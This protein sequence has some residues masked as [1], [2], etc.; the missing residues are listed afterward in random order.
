MRAGSGVDLDPHDSQCLGGQEGRGPVRDEM[1]RTSYN[2]LA[3][4]IAASLAM[5]S[6]MTSQGCREKINPKFCDHTTPAYTV[7]APRSAVPQ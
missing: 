6:A 4:A 1:N 2:G 5:S 3:G 7:A